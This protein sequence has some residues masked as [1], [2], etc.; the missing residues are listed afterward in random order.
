MHEHDRSQLFSFIIFC[1]IIKTTLLRLARPPARLFVYQ[2][3]LSFSF[4]W[5]FL[6]S[7]NSGF[8]FP[9]TQKL[10]R[11]NTKTFL[12][13]EFHFHSN[14]FSFDII[15]LK[16]NF[17][18]IENIS[19]STKSEK[20][21]P[22]ML[23]R[24]PDIETEPYYCLPVSGS[25]PW[26]QPTSPSPRGLSGLLSPTHAPNHRLMYQKKNDDGECWELV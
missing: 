21:Y 8:C 3:F 25:V 9:W 2:T 19:R 22:S 4:A 5:I 15:C 6:S 26:S 24:G 12:H 16:F 18:D 20:M 14:S 17:L 7:H 23:S 10:E 1:L 13:D 11:H